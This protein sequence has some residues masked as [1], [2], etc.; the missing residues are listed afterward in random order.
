MQRLA[1][2]IFVYFWVSEHALLS[3][4]LTLNEGLELLLNLLLGH[5][6]VLKVNWNAH[7][8]VLLHFLGGDLVVT[9]RLVEYTEDGGSQ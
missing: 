7:N 1:K 8:L 5:L 3:V 6:H 9:W 4:W 2:V